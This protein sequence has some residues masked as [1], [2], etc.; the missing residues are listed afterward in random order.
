MLRVVATDK[1]DT[2]K[3]MKD[4]GWGGRR[5]SYE[6]GGLNDS[7]KSSK[8][9]PNENCVKHG[10]KIEAY[11]KDDNA[12][13]CINCI[14][15]EDHKGHNLLSVNDAYDQWLSEVQELIKRANDQ[16]HTLSDN[17]IILNMS[18]DKLNKDKESVLKEIQTT[19]EEVVQ[20]IRAKEKQV[21]ES[22]LGSYESQN[23]EYQKRIKQI[24]EHIS[25]IEGLQAL[26]HTLRT[27][28]KIEFLRWKSSKNSS[29]DRFMELN[30]DLSFNPVKLSFNKDQELSSVAK[31]ISSR[32]AYEIV[33]SRD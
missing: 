19:F 11:C 33:V 10:K 24:E 20:K 6:V 3:K 12:V 14:L 28:Q 27:Y 23:K 26:N 25:S 1:K 4:A 31:L 5:G 8:P 22:L 2:A 30:V 29:L 15:N 16:K 32:A 7:A 17:R 9:P 18:L 13:L 21:V